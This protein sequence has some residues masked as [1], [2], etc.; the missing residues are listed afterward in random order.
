MWPGTVSPT[1][2][3][4]S[5]FG[6]LQSYDFSTRVPNHHPRMDLSTSPITGLKKSVFFHMMLFMKPLCASSS[7]DTCTRIR[8]RFF[9]VPA[10]TVSFANLPSSHALANPRRDLSGTALTHLHTS[11]VPSS[12]KLKISLAS[13]S[14]PSMPSFRVI[15]VL[16]FFAPQDLDC[17]HVSLADDVFRSPI[18]RRLLLASSP[19][20]SLLRVKPSFAACHSVMLTPTA[21]ARIFGS[22]KRHLS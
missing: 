12:L 10:G 15:S 6:F 19:P 21:E 11:T 9:C 14:R 4:R 16:R 7:S 22:N 8:V 13:S 17:F 5:L 2:E 18:A 20:D 3:L 1:F